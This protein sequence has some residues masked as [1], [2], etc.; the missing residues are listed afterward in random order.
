[1][2]TRKSP[3]GKFPFVKIDGK[4][5][6]D[7]ELIIDYLKGKFGDVA[8]NKLDKKQKAL[9]VL[10]EEVFSERLYWIMLYMRWQ[11]D[12]VWPIL[13]E[14]FFSSLPG[15]AKL[16]I[17]NLVRRK[18]LRDLYSQGTGRHSYEEVLQM[19]YKTLDAIAVMLGDNH[20]FQ[21]EKLTSIDATAFGFLAN[22]VWL[23]Y[24]DALKVHLQKHKNILL[25]CDTI[26]NSFYP[27]LSKPFS[28]ISAE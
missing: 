5:L 21:G 23:P 13:R 10:L 6:P 18:T 7:S 11:N 16:F 4:I 24:E 26:W 3:K 17:P 27:E 28:L 20:Y 25:F 2:P 14:A 15:F 9:T 8:D 19:G 22:I 1:M 12:A